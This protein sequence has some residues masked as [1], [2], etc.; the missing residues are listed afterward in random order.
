MTEHSVATREDWLEA[1][2]ALLNSPLTKCVFQVAVGAIP[3]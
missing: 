1:R 3:M 2:M